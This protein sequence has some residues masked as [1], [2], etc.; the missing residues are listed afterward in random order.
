M[1]LPRSRSCSGRQSN[2]WLFLAS[3]RGCKPSRGSSSRTWEIVKLSILI[4]VVCRVEVIWQFCLGILAGSNKKVLNAIDLAQR[5][6]L[7]IL[8][9]HW[10]ESLQWKSFMEIDPVPVEDSDQFEFMKSCQVFGAVIEETSRGGTK[11][12]GIK[13]PQASDAD[14]RPN[15]MFGMKSKLQK[16]EAVTTISILWS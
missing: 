11:D 2:R 7:C 15:Q 8:A 1:R 12:A 16:W 4:L 9:T 6:L 3:A 10:W 5:W 14:F 13:G